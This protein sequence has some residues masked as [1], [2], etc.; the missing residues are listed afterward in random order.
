MSRGDT[1]ALLALA[2]LAYLLYRN[3][4][5][6]RAAAQAQANRTTFTNRVFSI[7]ATILEAL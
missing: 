3:A 2:I 7:G 5:R 4:K 1:I 6:A